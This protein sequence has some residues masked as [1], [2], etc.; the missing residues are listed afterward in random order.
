MLESH[1]IR[2]SADYP[3]QTQSVTG[4]VPAGAV[5]VL[6]RADRSSWHEPSAGDVL[7]VILELS[8]DAGQTFATLLGFTA[9]SGDYYPGVPRGETPA[10][11]AQRSLESSADCPLPETAGESLTYKITVTTFAPLSTSVTID[12]S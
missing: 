10:A 3:A 12:W 1:L 2:P 5:Q 9:A 11:D 7:G 8:V 6:L 4:L